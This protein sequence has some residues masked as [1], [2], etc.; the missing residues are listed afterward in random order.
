VEIFLKNNNLRIAINQDKL[1]NKIN[2]RDSKPVERNKTFTTL[3]ML[4]F[5]KII[6]TTTMLLFACITHETASENQKNSKTC[7]AHKSLENAS[8]FHSK[9]TKKIGLK[10]SE[11]LKT[12]A[13]IAGLN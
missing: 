12:K 1:H 10:C 9:I 5:L 6:L 3:P 2:V 11:K 13:P 8:S 4:T 7:K